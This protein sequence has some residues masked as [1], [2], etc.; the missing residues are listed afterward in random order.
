MGDDELLK[1]FLCVFEDGQWESRIEVG[2]CSG[3]EAVC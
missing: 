2:N 1:V 3:G